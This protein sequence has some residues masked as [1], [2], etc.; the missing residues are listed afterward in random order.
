MKKGT[1]DHMP[2]Y[3]YQVMDK[4]GSQLDGKLEADHELAAIGRLRKMG[5]MIVEIAEVKE[6][7]F[8]KIF[9]GRGKVKVG[10]L[11]FFTRQLAAMLTAGIPLTRCLYTLGE[12]TK[13]PVLARIAGEVA[14]NVEGGIS[15]SESLRAYPDVFSPMFMD[16][17]KAGE[18]GGSLDQMLERLSGQLERDKSL[19]DSIRTATFYPAVILIFA[20]FVVLAMLFFVVPIFVGFFPADVQ[21]PLLTKIVIGL[22]DSLRD[23]WYVYQLVLLGI[24]LGI[25]VYMGSEH[26]RRIWDLIRFKLPLFGDLFIKA[27]T[28][29][30]A[31]TLSTLLS[32]GIPVLQALEAAGPASGSSQVTKAI[33]ATS[34]GIQQGQSIA[35]PLQRSG[36][37][38]PMVI[39]MVAVGEETGQ[40]AHLLERVAIFY[41][42]E[43]ATMTKG[44]TSIIEPLL[45]IFVGIII[46]VMV[47]AVYLPIFTVVTSVGG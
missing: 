35:V 17:V 46:A 15:F 32:G 2:L 37:F 8:K 31:R 28:A 14:R 22:S 5:Y 10:D 20:S 6:S 12:Q 7:S 44:L 42:E 29:R 47:L 13:N 26:G 18:I 11:S 41:E 9:Q 1:V 45:I 3:T 27:T 36:F 24:Y 38:P 30:F 21:L 16:M 33:Q 19:R 40:L 34:E 23:Y 4:A 43:V 39:N 25:R